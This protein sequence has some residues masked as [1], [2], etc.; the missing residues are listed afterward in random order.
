MK[1][2]IAFLLCLIMISSLFSCSKENI[3]QDTNKQDQNE[4]TET[5]SNNTTVE[6]YRSILETYRLIVEKFPIINQ[7]PLAFAAELSIQDE[8]EKDDFFKLYSSVH[9][10]Y[11]GKDQED[12]LSPHYKL[13][14]GYTTKD[15]NGDGVDELVLLTYD[16]R[17]I[18]V[19]SL[20]NGVPALLGS[21][22]K[23]DSGWTYR[24]WIDTEGC[25]HVIRTDGGDFYH[26][27]VSEISNGQLVELCTYGYDV[28]REN[29][30]VIGKLY[31]TINEKTTFITEQEVTEFDR[32]YGNPLNAGEA[33]NITM[34]FAKLTFTSLYT[35]AEIAM[36]MY[37][38][39]LKNEIKVCETDIEEYNYLKNCRTPYNRIPLCE[40]GNL[41]YVYMDVDGDSI[42][43]LVI[44]CGDTL[45]L[46]YY[47]GAVYVYSF[48]F[49]NMYQLNT[50]G[51][52]NWNH[53]G[54]NFEYG[55]KQLAFDGAELKASE[56][57]RIVN[58]GE[59]NA[60]YYIEGRQVSQEELQKYI[61]DNPKTK[62]EFSPLEVSW[63]KTISCRDTQCCVY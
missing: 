45:I 7:N 28:F 63:Q 16:Y 1:K 59:P 13:K 58:D 57:W 26:H 36:E 50:D 12:S 30:E 53:N 62:I 5:V 51:S 19:Y 27:S 40:L 47:E 38:A 2:Y 29:G 11:P 20:I 56:L 43:E 22:T 46:R 17:I 9:Q 18:A 21:Y 41:R 42:S 37:E 34:V 8:K 61:G 44:D 24:N 49:R 25:I 6:K 3:G 15:I 33:G 35:E 54:Q 14:C 55:E 60:E 32:Q 52:Y 4:N 23:K 31:Q 10:F 48:T 39:V